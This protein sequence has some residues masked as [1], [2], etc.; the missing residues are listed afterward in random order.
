[1]SVLKKI[2]LFP[3]FLFVAL[4]AKYL[5]PCLAM[6]SGRTDKKNSAENKVPINDDR[7][8]SFLGEELWSVSSFCY[9]SVWNK[10]VACIGTMQNKWGLGTAQQ[11]F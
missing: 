9:K 5:L 4:M 2:V 1:M 7:P 11:A 8:K 6:W 10:R 3:A